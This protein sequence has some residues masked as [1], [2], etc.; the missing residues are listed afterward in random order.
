MTDVKGK[1]IDDYDLDRENEQK[2]FWIKVGYDMKDRCIIDLM[3][4]KKYSYYD[5][6]INY[7]K[8]YDI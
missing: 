1:A 3:K 4:F 2:R 7:Q 8:F 6:I 5:L